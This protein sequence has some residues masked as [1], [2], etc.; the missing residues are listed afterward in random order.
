MS[1]AVEGRLCA[2]SFR[3]ADPD[4]CAS[5]DMTQHVV[6]HGLVN[7]L[8]LLLRCK[9]DRTRNIETFYVDAG[10]D[11]HAHLVPR[12]ARLSRAASWPVL[13]ARAE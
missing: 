3:S 11:K 6:T 13:A 12:S 7:E 4:G 8:P 1:V 10:T 9:R 5:P 2:T